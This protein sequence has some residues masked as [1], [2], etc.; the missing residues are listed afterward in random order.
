MSKNLTLGVDFG[1]SSSK[2]TLLSESG[3]IL[4]TATREYPSRCPRPGW[5][6]QDP[7]DLYAAFVG[8][9]REVLEK[10]GADSRN[11]AAVA[12]D[13]ATHMAVL[14]DENDQPLRPMIHWSDRRSS[15]QAQWL[16]ENR[17]ELLSR[18]SCN[19]VSAAWTL[20]QLLWLQEQEPEVLRRVRR[21]YFAKDYIRHLIT[22]DFC[23]D[24][25]ESM[26]AMLTD[27]REQVWSEELCALAGL[28]L[29][30]LPPI[31]AP[32]DIAGKVRKKTAEETGLCE[33]TP[34]LVGT[35]D[36]ALE[37][38]ASGA[39]E[40]GC[41]TVKLATAGRICP[42]TE[43]P[44]GNRQF[45]NYRHL[46]PGLWYPGT[47]T[48]SCAASY[49]W[50]RDTFG[51]PEKERAAAEDADAYAL[52][53]AAAAA[54]PAGS[55]GLFFHPYLLGEM[56]PYFDDQLR[57]SFTGVAMHHTKAH[58]TWAVL[59]GVAYSLRDSL[60]EIRARNI[61]VD[62]LLLI[63]GG[64]KGAIWRQIVSDVLNQPLTCTQ[65][66][67]SSLGSAMLAGVAA[68]LFASPAESVKKC[69]RVSG[70]VMPNPAD[71]EVYDRGFEAYRT[72]QKAL[73]GV[74]HQ[75]V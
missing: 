60:E 23:T 51:E 25:I 20:P 65:D 29:G 56:T 58:F 15:Q 24:Y 59:E 63:G 57:A 36:T 53:D 74:Y 50:Y 35:T 71:A 75:I 33:G 68:G 39:V 21:V 41:A 46:I 64:A 38:Y 54:V 1:G 3:Q 17:G 26:G 43:E 37:V 72:I 47:G 7:N 44:V 6:E 9:V 66:N 13:A 18:L 34:V 42:I 28:D 8:N 16:R 55:G 52:L 48:R 4:A 62:R 69:V 27:D 49:K 61:R 73:A 10:S 2:A 12:V 30:M 22:G 19:S 67:D 40:V 11:I 32:R 31:R 5:M 14:T 70:T 45:F